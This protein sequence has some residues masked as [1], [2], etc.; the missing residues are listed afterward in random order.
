MAD[1]A[2]KPMRARPLS[3]HL[4]VYRWSLT[5]VMSGAHRVTGIGL[6]VGVLLMAWFLLA[7]ASDASAFAVFSG[8][9]Q[10]I[11]GQLLLF[12]F[13]WA[14]FHH[15]FGGLRHALWDAGVGLDHPMR[16]YLAQGTL[17]GGFALTLIVWIVGYF[18]R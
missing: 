16:E 17:A 15:M 3:P 12:G 4:D 1:S 10:S 2:P 9:I 14:L 11:I 5:M 8:F 18:V 13:T 6:Y 7:L